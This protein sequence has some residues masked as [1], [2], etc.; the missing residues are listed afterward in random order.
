M[1]VGDPHLLEGDTRM[2]RRDDLL[3][4]G[5][6]AGLEVWQLTTEAVSSSHVYMEAQIF[7]PDSRRFLLHRS[8]HAH[9][10]D[11]NDPE[12][13]YLLCDLEN[14]GE[15]AP[16]TQET[17]ATA[18]SVSPDGQFIYYF[19]DR[20]GLRD[21]ALTLKRVRLDGTD[22]LE[23]ACV[24]C[25]IV[26]FPGGPTH[27][28]PLSTISADGTRLATAAFLGDG[29]MENAPYGLL[30][31]DL[32]TGAAEVVL[33]GSSWCN[34]HPQ[35]CRS[36]RGAAVRDILVQENHGC[37]F[38]A[39]GTVTTL[40]S[41][42]GADIHIIRDDGSDF[43]TMP[44]GRD[45]NEFCQGHQCWRGRSTWAITSTGTHSP[46]EA[47]LIEGRAG[48]EAGHLG[49]A[50]PGACR[51]DLSR[52]CDNPHFYHF[53]TDI[54]GR[55]LISDVRH[56]DGTDGL[57]LFELG[58]AGRSPL[59]HGQRLLRPRST[60]NKTCHVHPFLSPD[61]RTGFFNSD[62]TGT[63]QAYMVRGWR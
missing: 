25:P 28:Y 3:D 27:I 9:G 33:S 52:S 4:A 60:W 38:D 44:W 12:H 7:T 23:I 43:R 24:P 13:R 8:A 41:G 40:V 36:P 20:T 37:A 63:M 32:R 18:P 26:G 59:R 1:A 45:G 17:G 58:R 53:A 42:L 10:S 56:R 61:G 39:S 35:Y 31:F 22:R 49:L 6:P 34:L 47:Q 48:V 29:V 11:R 57:Y 19:S 2:L 21:G 62:E 46:S 16:I 14:H 30:V 15:L 50:S 51:N 54:A 5:S 55:R